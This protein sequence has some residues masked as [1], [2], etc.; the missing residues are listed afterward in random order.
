MH[1]QEKEKYYAVKAGRKTG[2]FQT[3]GECKK[4]VD[5][6]SRAI[7]KSFS[8]MEE[9]EEYLHGKG[10]TQNTPKNN[11][12]EESKIKKVNT[13]KRP[14]KKQNVE[15]K[16]PKQKVE[17]DVAF[18]EK[19]KQKI[20]EEIR[21][22]NVERKKEDISLTNII[23]TELQG[24]ISRIRYRSEESGWSVFNII[25]E[26]DPLNEICITGTAGYIEEGDLVAVQGH[27]EKHKIYGDQYKADVIIK[28]LPKRAKDIKRYLIK[29]IKGVGEKTASRIVDEYGEDTFDV[30]EKHPEMLSLVS[31][32]S[33]KKA[34]RIAKQFAKLNMSRQEQMFFI[35][36]GLSDKQIAEIKKKYEDDYM[37]RINENPYCLIEDINGIGFKRADLIAKEIG[38]PE[39]SPFRIRAGIEYIMDQASVLKGHVYLPHDEVVASTAGEL[40]VEDEKIEQE[41][42][43]L[44]DQKRIACENNNIY[45]SKFYRYEIEC[46]EKIKKMIKNKENIDESTVENRV[47]TIEIDND[48]CLDESQRQAVVETVMNKVM[49]ITGGPGVGK[50]TTLDIVIKYLEKYVTDN[51]VLLAPTGKAAKRMSEQTKRPASTIHR[52]LASLECEMDEESDTDVIII[53]EM[54]MV[55]ISLFHM[56]LENIDTDTK[57]I[58]VGDVDQIPSV[59]PGLVLRDLI[60]SGAIPTARLTKIHRQATEN[61]IVTNAHKINKSIMVTLDNKD[62]DFFF[63]NRGT[64]ESALATILSLYTKVYPEYLGIDPTDVQ[65]L[66]PMKKGKLGTI[67]LNRVIQNTVNTRQND[68]NELK[69]GDTLF[70]EGDKVMHIKNDY[71]LEWRNGNE[72]GVGVFNGETGFIRK[73]DKENEVMIVEFDDGRVAEYDFEDTVELMLA[74]AITIHKSQGSEFPAVIIPVVKSGV[75]QLYNK[76][77]LYTAVTR[78]KT[79]LALIGTEETVRRMIKNKSAEKRN[80]SLKERL[81][82]N[83]S[84]I[85]A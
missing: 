79:S 22:E 82:K 8:T 70:R 23:N 65:I 48:K 1:E 60:D 14:E 33:K 26:D 77:L 83:M 68:K 42:I 20:L 59:G 7:F 44:I 35:K 62:T 57:L 64:E 4:Q 15:E 21:K 24:Q 50:T 39:D 80:T 34:E 9:A 74:Y 3:W 38:V 49:I 11:K 30:I 41:L 53:D 81:T 51:I 56:L 46:A 6:Y 25:S 75:P 37:K 13:R 36:L 85:S 29:N 72:R 69:K 28:V 18:R 19:I 45:L 43:A 47:T 17:D 10:K 31:K 84:N 54:S 55:D 52:F 78:A 16:Q 61:H 73:I 71:G 76:N 40:H 66:A 58:M 5:G 67:E 32:I 12:T 2:I 27:Y 63:L